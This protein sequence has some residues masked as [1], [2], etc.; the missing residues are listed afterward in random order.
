MAPADNTRSKSMSTNEFKIILA[1]QGPL[2]DL[3]IVL[4][5]LFALRGHNQTK[6]L[7]GEIRVILGMAEMVFGIDGGM[8]IVSKRNE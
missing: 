5:P 7:L 2:D 1:C 6:G 4:D 3:P 8:D